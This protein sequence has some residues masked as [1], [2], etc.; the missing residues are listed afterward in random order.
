VLDL[1]A[2]TGL[3]G[4]AALRRGAVAVVATDRAPEMLRQGPDR[5]AVQADAYALPFADG[6]FD[7]VVAAFVVNHLDDPG[8]GL[9]ECRRVAPALVASSFDRSWNHPAKSVVDAVMAEAGFVEPAW[10]AEVLRSND[11]VKDPGELERLA[12]LAGY[13]DVAVRRVEVATGIAD[14]ASMVAWRWGM[15]HLAPFVASLDG[16]RRAV[17]RRRAE[18]AVASLEPVVVPML[19]L[20]ARDPSLTGA[21]GRN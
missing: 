12:R 10:Y 13:V 9:R 11:Q 5:T 21:T 1:G 2:G 17:L 16:P 19:A 6:S 8:R 3:A 14:P 18:E 20:Q 15:A 7:L 4:R